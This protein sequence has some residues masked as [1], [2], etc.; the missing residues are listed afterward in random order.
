MN[1]DTIRF[2][3]E[4][5]TFHWSTL[6]RSVACGFL[7][8]ALKTTYR[9]IA[10]IDSTLNR[11]E[12]ALIGAQT[13]ASGRREYLIDKNLAQLSKL[14]QGPIDS[15]FEAKNDFLQGQDSSMERFVL[16]QSLSNGNQQRN[17]DGESIWARR[18]F[19]SHYGD[20][21]S[22]VIEAYKDALKLLDLEAFFRSG[23]HLDFSCGGA[24]PFQ[25]FPDYNSDQYLVFTSYQEFRDYQSGLYFN[26]LMFL[27]NK[28]PYDFLLA[29]LAILA[30]SVIAVID[31]RFLS[32][33]YDCAG[34]HSPSSETKA[35]LLT[36]QQEYYDFD[37]KKDH[38]RLMPDRS[39]LM[40]DVKPTQDLEV[41]EA[42]SKNP[43]PLNQSEDLQASVKPVEPVKPIKPKPKPKLTPKPSSIIKS[44]PA[45]QLSFQKDEAAKCYIEELFLQAE[46]EGCY[47]SDFFDSKRNMRILLKVDVKTWDNFY[48]SQE[49]NIN[50]WALKKN[51]SG[52]KYEDLDRLGKWFVV[53]KYNADV[54]AVRIIGA[55]YNQTCLIA[56]SGQKFMVVMLKELPNDVQRRLKNCH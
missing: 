34:V 27:I 36:L 47:I 8:I 46:K 43:V 41:V 5:P 48:K 56:P 18:I 13:Y 29:A 1:T 42:I 38:D 19:N 44:C 24:I 11:I 20:L 51:S 22:H 32:N 30:F 49:F 45:K 55:P 52:L 54:N 9:L 12:S 23:H 17:R 14:Y 39:L 26:R 6:R 4:R 37:F 40:D 35:F 21:S 15:D 25:I 10:N 31:Y 3:L 16:C 2:N 50:R 28:N 7:G 53:K 33:L